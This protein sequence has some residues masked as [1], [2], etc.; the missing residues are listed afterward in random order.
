MNLR[1][2]ELKGA[3]TQMYKEISGAT[4]HVPEVGGNRDVSLQFWHCFSGIQRRRNPILLSRARL[5]RKSL[6][7]C[8]QQLATVRGGA[9][10]GFDRLL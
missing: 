8:S 10:I 4:D 9:E 6:L 1:G 5:R 3:R 2:E 7:R